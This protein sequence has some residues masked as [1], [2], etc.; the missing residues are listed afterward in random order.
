MG[1]SGDCQIDQL[2][3][4]DYATISNGQY[5]E[6]FESFESFERRNGGQLTS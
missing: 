2:A 3:I 4:V 1:L 6:S 5:S